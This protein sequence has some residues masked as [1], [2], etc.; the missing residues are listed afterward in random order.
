MP[1]LPVLPTERR[2]RPDC[3]SDP[4]ARKQWP[5]IN[6]EDTEGKEQLRAYS[7][8]LFVSFV[9]FCGSK[10]V[11]EVIA[12]TTRS[13]ACNRVALASGLGRVAMIVLARSGVSV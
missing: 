3:P 9:L 6:T 12:T 11:N 1:S 8:V 7:F 5:Q 10:T 4:P 13:R 2:S